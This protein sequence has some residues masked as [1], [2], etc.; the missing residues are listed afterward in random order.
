MTIFQKE[1]LDKYGI[2]ISISTNEENPCIHIKDS[3]KVTDKEDMTYI[4]GKI[5]F[6]HFDELYGAG[7][8]RTWKS[9]FRE[10]KAHNFLYK[11]GYKRERTGSVDIDQK[12]SMWRRF[13]YAILS[14]F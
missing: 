5:W 12:E 14:I 7:F 11:I 3:Y 9:A 2:L 8:D 4:L 1:M 13:L 6:Y 10:W